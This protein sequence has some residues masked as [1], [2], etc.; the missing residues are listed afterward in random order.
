[1]RDDL[2]RAAAPIT[3]QPG[4]VI[5]TY[6]GGKESF[7]SCVMQRLL[8]DRLIGPW[9][10]HVAVALDSSVVLEASTAPEDNASTWSGVMLSG[11]VRLQLIPDLLASSTGYIALR[12]R[13]AKDL[14]NSFGTQVP[15]IALMLGSG[16]STRSLIEAARHASLILKHLV[17]EESFDW[18]ASP[19]FIARTLR[20]DSELRAG[21]EK[22]LRAG[23]SLAPEKE[24]F[25]SQLVGMLLWR[26]SLIR[27]EPGTIT[28]C[29]LFDLLK[30]ADWQDVTEQAYGASN[31]ERW[32]RT[33]VSDWQR[34]YAEE[35]GVARFFRES[36][37][38]LP[39]LNHLGDKLGDFTAHLDALRDH[40]DEQGAVLGLTT[41]QHPKSRHLP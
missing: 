29:G 30:D 41:H 4:D 34:Q 39:M 28:P 1:M 8:F 2:L 22:H 7:D 23:E 12:H 33:P 10:S 40:L 25:C 37:H 24:Y 15:R 16:Y 9:F 3:P 17:S 20:Q 21:I 14:I 11:G 19:D 27:S 31:R 35:V 18:H 26:A 32:Q 5:F 38:V 13:S 6:S 36:E